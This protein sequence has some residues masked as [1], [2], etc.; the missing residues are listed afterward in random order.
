MIPPLFSIVVP[1][2][3]SELYLNKCIQST[4]NQSYRNF[5]LILVN[6]GSVD[7]SLEICNQFK[8]L[9]NRIKVLSQENTG[10][11]SAR[12]AGI[13]IASGEYITFLDSDDFLDL[14]YLDCFRKQVVNFKYD[15]LVSGFLMYYEDN[16]N[17]NKSFAVEATFSTK[18][19]IDTGAQIGKL[20]IAS[21]LSGP[22]AKCIKREI[23]FDN[24]I[25]FDSNFHFGEDAIFN[26]NYINKICSISVNTCVGYY[27]VQRTT[28]SLV[29]HKYSFN[30]TN[31]YIEILT[32]L[33]KKNKARFGI[34]EENYMKLIKRE[35]TLYKIAAIQSMYIPKYKLRR[36]DRYCILEEQVPNLDLNLLPLSSIHYY[37]LK[38]IFSRKNRKLMDVFLF[39]YSK[40]L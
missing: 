18:E 15:L 36:T 24:K 31:S 37:I 23:L 10:V 20:E 1:V 13:S 26:H 28:D 33:R 29:K 40:L 11:S 2:Y 27:Y 32:T 16:P 19:F 25:L 38:I 6:D 30:K 5:E 7:K 3:N 34:R 4:L 12:N 14:S 8:K 22:F 21:L 17:A 39:L 35:Q 9:D